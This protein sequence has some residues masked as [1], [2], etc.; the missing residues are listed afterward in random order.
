MSAEAT[1]LSLRISG[2]QW[3]WKAVVTVWVPQ[4]KSSVSGSTR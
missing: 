3:R 4:R 1:G 2:D